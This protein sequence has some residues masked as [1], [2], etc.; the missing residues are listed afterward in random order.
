MGRNLKFDTGAKADSPST[1]PSVY[2]DFHEVSIVEELGAAVCASFSVPMLS[3]SPGELSTIEGLHLSGPL[4]GIS[5]VTKVFNFADL[6]CPPRSV[7]VSLRIMV[8]I[9]HNNRLTYLQEANWYTPEPGQ[10]YRP[11]IALPRQLQAWNPA[12]NSCQFI[13][14]RG[15]DPPRALVP[16]TAMA[17]T[18]TQ[19]EPQPSTIA[20]RPSATPDPGPKE[21]SQ[22]SIPQNGGTWQTTSSP[23]SQIGTDEDPKQKA[24]PSV[25]SINDANEDSGQHSYPEQSAQSNTDTTSGEGVHLNSESSKDNDDN[26][27]QVGQQQ[28]N[29][30]LVNDPES[31]RVPESTPDEQGNVI[32][33]DSLRPD[34]AATV[35][36]PMIQVLRD[37]I[38]IAGT[39][40]S[41]G[42]PP[43]TVSGTPMAL[44]SGTLV[45]G[46]FSVRIAQPPL[47]LT[48]GQVTNLNGVVIEQL[49]TGISVSG[50]T[51][52][53]GAP[54][55]MVSGSPV[56]LGA[57]ALMIGSSSIPIALPGQPSIQGPMTNVDGETVQPL[58]RWIAVAGTTLR[59]GGLPIK[60]SGTLISLGSNDLV[61]GTRSIR[62]ATEDPTQIVATIAGQMITASPTAIELG[63][64]TLTPGDPGLIVGGTPV[65]LNYAGQLV[66]GSKTIPLPSKSSDRQNASDA[67]GS[68]NAVNPNNDTGKG[69]QAF[70]GSGNALKSLSAGI[71]FLW[72]LCVYLICL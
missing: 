36:S 17:P 43:I 55:I 65:S 72:L 61:I 5:G 54:P 16:A 2:V 59:P 70:R 60:V 56:S 71:L 52:T 49:Q 26:P 23:G 58:V 29:G 50:S 48:P 33:I 69:V 34:Q 22:A 31:Q 9:W 67:I 64:S 57:S 30:G 24:D 25:S 39:T 35:N 12:Y 38:S 10:P 19:V 27:D 45:F 44:D 46:S 20:P 11:I 42:A 51:I 68:G 18:V 28:S 13:V 41:A 32:S 37:A 47:S 62:F 1:S 40:L 66:V 6:P 15:Y 21:T 3:F 53:P 7:M 4:P 63:G 14:F 8:Q